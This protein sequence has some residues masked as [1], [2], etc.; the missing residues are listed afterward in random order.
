MAV[1]EGFIDSDI[2]DSN[3]PLH[4]LQF[5]D[6]V[7]QEKRVAVSQKSLDLINVHGPTGG[8]GIRFGGIDNFT[9]G[10][11]RELYRNVAV[12]ALRRS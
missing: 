9:H 11:N 3:D 1:E 4:P 6:P 10:L 7:Q 5:Q 8:N 12:E 2:L